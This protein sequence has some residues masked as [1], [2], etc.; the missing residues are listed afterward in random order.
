MSTVKF[1]N[2]D[3]LK[4]LQSKIY[5]LTKISLSQ[6]DLLELGVDVLIE[7]IDLLIQR[8]TRGS[9]IVDKK[10][11]EAIMSLSKDWGPGSE[12]SSINIDDDLYR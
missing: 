11:L 12:H 9:R 7:N 4:E 8:L 10:E 5:L 3:K 6:K 2:I 1:S